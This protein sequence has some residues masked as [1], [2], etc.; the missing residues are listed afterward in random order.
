MKKLNEN[1]W[2]LIVFLVLLGILFL[3]LLVISYLANQYGDGLPSST[4][5]T[6]S[7][8]YYEIVTK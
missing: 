4:R 1:G 8:H 2:G 6:T 3:T 5:G 7:Y